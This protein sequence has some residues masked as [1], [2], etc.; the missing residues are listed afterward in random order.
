MS[1]YKRLHASLWESTDF[2]DEPFSER[3]AFMWLVAKAAWKAHQRR[4]GRH[5]VEVKRGE[6]VGTTRGLARTWQWSEARVRRYFDRLSERRTLRRTADAHATRIT[7]CNYDEFQGV[8]DQEAETVTHPAT[9]I[10]KM[11][12][13]R[14]NKDTPPISPTPNRKSLIPEDWSVPDRG[15]AYATDRGLD[16][17]EIDNIRDDFV[18]HH[19]DAGTKRA[20]WDRSWQ[21]WVRTHIHWGDVLSHA[22]RSRRK[23]S[24]PRVYLVAC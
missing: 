20:G 17:A 12:L 21:T 16:D 3:E 15:R 9:H 8:D 22:R 19:R 14:M 4:V 2:A 11:G 13:N 18:A 5:V 1:G 23:T 6:F 24:R 10:N 7:I